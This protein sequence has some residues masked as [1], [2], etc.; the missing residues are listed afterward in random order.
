MVNYALTNYQYVITPRE[1]DEIAKGIYWD[2]VDSFCN[3]MM[4]VNF[5]EPISGINNVELPSTIRIYT[6]EELDAMDR[7]LAG[8]ARTDVHSPEELD[9]TLMAPTMSC[10]EPNPY[11]ISMLEEDL[12]L[13]THNE[14]KFDDEFLP[15]YSPEAVSTNSPSDLVDP[16]FGIYLVRWTD[17]SLERDISEDHTPIRATPEDD[18]LDVISGEDSVEDHIK[19]DAH[20]ASDAQGTT[21]DDCVVDDLLLREEFRTSG[22]FTL[23]TLSSRLGQKLQ[24]AKQKLARGFEFLS[25][26]KAISKI[27][28]YKKR[29]HRK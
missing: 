17:E 12:T 15:I 10:V 21:G 20:G 1:V 28:G 5:G 7:G 26:K 4:H 16:L 6:D 9:A 22:L 23:S 24:K 19:D 27:R 11:V 13:R 29:V 25:P 3:Y 18:G 14:V 8:T 2:D